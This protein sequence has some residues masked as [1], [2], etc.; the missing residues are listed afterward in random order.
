MNIFCVR[1]TSAIPIAHRHRNRSKPATELYPTAQLYS[2]S[3]SR[4]VNTFVLIV[5]SRDILKNKYSQKPQLSCSH[6]MVRTP[7]ICI[8][9]TRQLI[10]FLLVGYKPLVHRLS[11]GLSSNTPLPT[12]HH[13]QCVLYQ[14]LSVSESNFSAEIIYSRN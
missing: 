10:Q 5:R 6:P 9:L 7:Y 13:P 11:I 14:A 12:S 1:A 2:V 8:E 4:K 3:S